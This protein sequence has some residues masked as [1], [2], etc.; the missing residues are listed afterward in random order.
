MTLAPK[1]ALFAGLGIAIV[2]A[3]AGSASGSDPT[4]VSSAGSREQSTQL[5][6]KAMDGGVPNGP[7]TNAVISNDKRY[8]RAIAFESEASDLVPNDTDGVKDVFVVKRG[9]KAD[10][11]GSPWTPGATVLVSRTASGAPADGPSFSPAIG[12]GFRSKPKCVGFLSDATNLVAGD[13]NGK[14]DA[15]L[16]NLKGGKPRRISLPGGRQSNA[17]TTAIAVSGNCKKIAFVTGADLYVTNG[18]GKFKKLATKGAPADPSFSTGVKNDLV[19]GDSAGVYRSKGASKSPKLVAPGGRNPAFNDV[20]RQVLTYEKSSGGH[21]QIAYRDLGKKEQII[22][23]FKGAEG[24]GDSRDPVIGNTGF[25]VTFSTDA[26]NLG[27]NAN[28]RQG[29]DNGKPDSYLYTNVRDITLVE[30]VQDKGVPLKG[31]GDNPSMSFYANY[32][33]F[34]SPAP[35]DAAEGAHQIYMRY[36]G[37]V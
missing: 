33:V 6:S 19:F 24:N 1:R 37:P 14:T 20:K 17:A 15:F 8:A 11:A 36:L 13:T 16:A 23:S 9:G 32:I 26:S 27:T 5:I 2:T 34:D 12:G 29:D 7:S 21:E 31:G 25:Y 4:T 10:N 3:T 28:S 22:S 35:V 18:K 30:S